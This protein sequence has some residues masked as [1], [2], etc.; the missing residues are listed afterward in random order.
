M[1]RDSSDFVSVC[2]YKY[3]GD[4]FVRV[5]AQTANPSFGMTTTEILKEAFCGMQLTWVYMGIFLS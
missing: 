2:L 1:M 5:Y 3:N 4:K